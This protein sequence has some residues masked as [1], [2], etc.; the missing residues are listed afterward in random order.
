MRK[1]FWVLLILTGCGSYQGVSDKSTGSNIL[2]KAES[3][4]EYELIII[5]S[6][7][8]RWFSINRRPVNYHTLSF[9]EQ[10]N[11]RYARAWNEKVD[12]QGRYRT[13]NYPFENRIDY[14][15]STDYGL[16][17]NYQLY[18]YF[19]YIEDMYGARYNFP[20]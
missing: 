8:D 17:L 14:N 3:G 5:D 6:G 19:Q 1:L 18:Y 7:F 13:A 15:Q 2:T 4:D 16:E 12:Q 20:N 9:Y 11:A 10:Q